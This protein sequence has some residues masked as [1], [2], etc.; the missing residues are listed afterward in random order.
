MILG[1]ICT[2]SCTFCATKKGVPES[3]KTTELES[4]LGIVKMLDLRYVIITSVTRDDLVDG[5]LHVYLDAVARLKGLN[6]EIKVEALTPDFRNVPDA[7]RA[8]A[9]SGLDVFGH[10]IETVKRLYP[11][12]RPEADHEA[13]LELLREVKDLSGGS[14]CTKTGFMLGLGER[15]EEVIELLRVLRDA[16]VDIVTIGQYLRPDRRCRDAHEYVLPEK[17]AYYK[18]I[19][20]K[21]GIP[22][23]SAGSFVRSS[24]RAENIF[25]DF[26]NMK[27]GI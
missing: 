12:I 23:V 9:L 10:N 18:K 1:D 17:F 16:G 15:E 14:K 5:G 21:N 25:N 6:G 3:I 8:I 24:Y 19:A 7:S 11:V 20:E 2:R 13:S 22:H 4:L 26:I 27:R